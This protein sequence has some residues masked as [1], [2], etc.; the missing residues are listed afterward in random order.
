MT[1]RK[2]KSV[3]FA[4]EKE[5][6]V[7]IYLTSD[8]GHNTRKIAENCTY[9]GFADGPRLIFLEVAL[10]YKGIVR[11]SKVYVKVIQMY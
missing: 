3:G 11:T 2:S 5:G 8:K 4:L 6:K 10:F 1:L 9:W 7:N